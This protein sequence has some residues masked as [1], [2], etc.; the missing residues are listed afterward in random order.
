ML[1]GDPITLSSG[2]YRLW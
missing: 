2:L 1:A